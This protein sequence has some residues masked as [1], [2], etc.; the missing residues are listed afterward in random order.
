MSSSIPT[1]P[2]SMFVARS[3]LLCFLGL[4]GLLAGC[5]E[6]APTSTRRNPIQ[7]PDAQG[8]TDQQQG[9]DFLRRSSEFDPKQVHRKILFHF[10]QWLSKQTPDANWKPDEWAQRVPQRYQPMVGLESLSSLTLEPYDA[11]ILQEASWLRDIARSSVRVNQLTP[12]TQAILGDNPAADLIQTAR[13]F[14]WT[15]SNLQLDADVTP[16]STTRFNCDVLLY[17]WEAILLGR[18]TV[19]ERSLVFIMLA[20]QLNLPVVMLGVQTEDP[21]TVRDWLPALLSGGQLYLF[22]MRLGTPVPGL[23]GNHV[24][25]LSELQANPQLLEQLEVFPDFPYVTKPADLDHV[26]ALID[27]SP[28]SLSHRMQLLESGLSG[29]SSLAL[30][31]RPSHVAAQLASI[32]GLKQIGAWTQSFDIFASRG[33][34]Q[35]D[36]TAVMSFALE[37][38]LFDQNRTPLFAARTLH[39]RGQFENTDEQ[40][41]ARAMYLESR[42]P[43]RDIQ[44]LAMAALQNRPSH[45]GPP[46]ENSE[47]EIQDAE[48]AQQAA[49]NIVY[50]LRRTKQNASYWLGTLAM[51]L[52]NYDVAVD[53]FQK[54]VLEGDSMT[55]WTSGATFNMGRSL[56]AL[57]RSESATA[58]LEKAVKVFR[59]DLDSPSAAACHWHA[60]RI[61]QQLS[62]S[63]STSTPVNAETAESAASEN[64]PIQ[65]TEAEAGTDAPPNADAPSTDEANSDVPNS[66]EP[67]AITSPGESTEF[68]E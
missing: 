44:K 42:I 25:T 60:L 14:E 5:E 58:L 24:A 66:E 46:D 59:S 3:L 35:S 62:P 65:N 32:S 17:P 51:D 19:A 11:Q 30:T 55:I 18:G 49:A 8:N 50:L 53:F 31:T 56:E 20:R 40:V 68:D 63:S 67:Q 39:F 45:G 6:S 7:T 28:Q 54:R 27:A 12:A 34:L 61:Q 47:Q 10:Q 57:C 36:R 16:G 26:V 15:L 38:S 13:L 48:N 22:D 29:D 33:R 41:G 64:A 1:H 23:G 2:V 4:G 9:L 21:A 37:H 52:G 43:D